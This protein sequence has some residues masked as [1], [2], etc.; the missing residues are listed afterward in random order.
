MER[1]EKM[2]RW[3]CDNVLCFHEWT[4][5]F[6]SFHDQRD[7]VQSAEGGLNYQLVL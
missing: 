6:R 3:R 2:E 5:N 7:N 4:T 1:G